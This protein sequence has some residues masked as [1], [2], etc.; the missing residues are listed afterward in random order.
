MVSFSWTGSKNNLFLPTD[1]PWKFW[2]GKQQTNKFLRSALWT[3]EYCN[4]G[5]IGA[6]SLNI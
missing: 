6:A 2:I 1:P 3:I 5:G 4:I